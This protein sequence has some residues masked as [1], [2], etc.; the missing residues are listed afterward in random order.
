MC[1]GTTGKL[2]R[3]VLAHLTSQFTSRCFTEICECIMVVVGLIT[4]LAMSCKV[5]VLFDLHIKPLP[6]NLTR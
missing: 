2:V 3:S 1:K 6:T 4:S 5:S